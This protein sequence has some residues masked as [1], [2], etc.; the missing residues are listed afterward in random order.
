METPLTVTTAIADGKIS[1]FNETALLPALAALGITDSRFQL[2]L[3]Q[4]KDIQL[5]TNLEKLFRQLNGDVMESET[6]S[7]DYDEPNAIVSAFAANNFGS[8]WVDVDLAAIQVAGSGKVDHAVFEWHPNRVTVTFW[9]GVNR[10]FPENFRKN[11][12]C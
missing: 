8:K 10:F 7:V 11:L 6:I 4:E 2:M 5:R 9:V 1:K 3:Q 12:P